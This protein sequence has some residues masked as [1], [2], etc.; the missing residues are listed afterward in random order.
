MSRKDVSS[1]GDRA[2]KVK[3]CIF[4]EGFRW[5]LTWRKGTAM[6]DCLFQKV[7][8][9]CMVE[10]SEGHNAGNWSWKLGQRAVAEIKDQT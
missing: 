8:T 7:L 4:Q 1:R 6:V 9:G 2:L 5:M 10:A 3:F